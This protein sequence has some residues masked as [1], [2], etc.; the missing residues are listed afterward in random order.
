MSKYVKADRN[1]PFLLP[2]DLPDWLPE[3]E[4]AHFVIGA[5][6]RVPVERYK[7]NTRGT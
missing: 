2:P 4:L 6:E 7:V 1:Q 3:D 5:V